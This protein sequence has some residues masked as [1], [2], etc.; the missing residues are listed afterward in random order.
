MISFNW[1]KSLK[2]NVSVTRMSRR[3]RV[4][5]HGALANISMQLESRVLL[6]A[7]ASFDAT[8][9]ALH[10]SSTEAESLAISSDANQNVTLNGV[11]VQNAGANVSSAE[12]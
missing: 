6:T 1:L 9:H 10:V 7:T 4:K 3:S 11:V 5:A 8:T 2:K 12:V